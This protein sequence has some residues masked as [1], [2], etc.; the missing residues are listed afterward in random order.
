[1]AGNPIAAI[2][3]A[4]VVVL[5]VAMTQVAFVVVDHWSERDIELRSSLVF[6]S[7]R[8]SVKRGLELKPE[9][10]LKAY[11]ERLAE[12]E[13]LLALGYCDAEGKLLYATRDMPKSVKCPEKGALHGDSYYRTT[14]DRRPISVA[15]FPLA[16]GDGG[17]EL[18]VLH[19]LTFT[20][21]RAHE[22]ELYMALALVGVAGGLGL[23]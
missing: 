12:D 20:Q 13:R 7:I 15:I 18:L 19:D 2:S 16:V 4:G 1:M 6:R 8:D 23:L 11:F 14:E 17:G 3:L 10:S 9:F 22:A 5:I 21:R